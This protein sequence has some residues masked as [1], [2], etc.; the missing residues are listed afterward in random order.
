METLANL[1]TTDQT[2]MEPKNWSLQIL[3]EREIDKER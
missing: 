3:R 1:K 2:R